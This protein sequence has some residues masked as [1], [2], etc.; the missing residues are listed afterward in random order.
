[1]L[2]DP[3]PDPPRRRSSGHGRIALN[4]LVEHLAASGAPSRLLALAAL[5]IVATFCWCWRERCKRKSRTALL[6]DYR[7]L[8]RDLRSDDP[9][10]AAHLERVRPPPTDQIE[11]PAAS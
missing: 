3:S 4:E 7:D 6:R 5:L 9:P 10:P 11:P 1:M 2:A 8:L